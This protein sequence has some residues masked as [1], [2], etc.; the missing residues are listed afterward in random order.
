MNAEM[1]FALVLIVGS[2]AG[3]YLSRWLPPSG[4]AACGLALLPL[5]GV[6]LSYVFC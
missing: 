1:I 3:W 2:L 4:K 5:V 6:W